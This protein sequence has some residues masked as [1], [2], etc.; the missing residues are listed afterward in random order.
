[1][2]EKESPEIIQVGPLDPKKKNS[3]IVDG[4]PPEEATEKGVVCW[5]NGAQYS[6]WARVCSGGVLLKCGTD[7]RWRRE[8]R[9]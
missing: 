4:P 8:G 3:P 6:P 1:M 5:F 2:S 9:C 7:G